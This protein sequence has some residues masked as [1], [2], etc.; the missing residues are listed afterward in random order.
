MSSSPRRPLPTAPTKAPKP[1]LVDLVD[2]DDDS[3]EE[4]EQ[5][6]PEPAEGTVTPGGQAKRVPPIVD[7]ANDSSDSDIFEDCAEEQ[8]REERTKVKADPDGPQRC[9][10]PKEVMRVFEA[11]GPVDI[12]KVRAR[13]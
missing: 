9:A 5:D 11:V 12:A 10:S 4:N 3:E 2:Y 1:T 7:L 6:G 8:Q 13:R